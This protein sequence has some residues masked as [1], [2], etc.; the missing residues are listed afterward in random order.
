MAIKAISVTAIPM[1]FRLI[2]SLIMVKYLSST[3]RVRKHIRDV[4]AEISAIDHRSMAT[5]WRN[6]TCNFFRTR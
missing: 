2:D 4:A 1:I 3:S 5:D 6:G